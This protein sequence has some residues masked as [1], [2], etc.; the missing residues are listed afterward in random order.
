MMT[1]F[2][3]EIDFFFFFFIISTLAGY[4]KFNKIYFE[5]EMIASHRQHS[6]QAKRDSSK[7]LDFILL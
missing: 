7:T 5:P 3:S 6:F 4:W 1:L 2:G